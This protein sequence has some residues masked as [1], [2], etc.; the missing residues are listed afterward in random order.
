[1]KVIKQS[2][3]IILSIVLS[4]NP[5][6]FYKTERPLPVYR[7]LPC[8]E[9]EKIVSVFQKGLASGYNLTINKDLEAATGIS[10]KFDSQAAVILGE[11]ARFSDDQD[12]IQNIFRI[13]LVKS[14]EFFTFNVRGQV[15]PFAPPYLT[16][17]KINGEEFCSR[18]NLTYFKDFPVGVLSNPDRHCGRRKILHTELIVNGVNTKPGDW[19]WHAAIH[20]RNKSTFKY[21]CGGSLVS[22]RFV[23]TAAHCTSI[24]GT[25]VLPDSLGV[26]LGKYHL[27][28][29]D[30][31][32]QEKEVLDV[33]VHNEFRTSSLSN[34]IALLKL[35][36]EAVFNNYVQPA[37]LWNDSV[38]D[39]L[40]FNTYGT[41]VGWGFDQTD[42]LT[43]TL[44]AVNMPQIS[45]L[46]CIY[47]K[48]E[49]YGNLLKDKKR[50]CA[51][52]TNGTTACN[53]DS[54]GA[55]VYFVPDIADYKGSLVPGA[56]YIKGIV[57][58]T[59]SR[60]DVSICDPNA[61]AIFIDV[62]KYL[63]WIKTIMDS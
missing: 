43:S 17:L 8:G 53:G 31:A 27:F 11:S 26:V 21:I 63:Q 56:W 50:F 33:Y 7:A 44:H 57:S 52:Y 20:R 28:R 24:Q 32:I 34:D 5:I 38:Y 36:T 29:S 61:Y 30:I 4:V 3:V 19:P 41:V 47:S 35:K 23:L 39:R 14:S 62:A 15:A 13:L 16:S 46:D 1:M 55:F 6:K 37:C 58:T 22:K 48:P 2:I 10:L 49:F 18:P 25:P 40:K 9:N 42:S 45:E 60:Q 51:G 59:L 54:G 12:D